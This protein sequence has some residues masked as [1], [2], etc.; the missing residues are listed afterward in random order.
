[1]DSSEATR[2]F[3]DMASLPISACRSAATH[4]RLPKPIDQG[5]RS[6]TVDIHADADGTSE[7]VMA[8]VG[9]GLQ[10]VQVDGHGA[11]KPLKPIERF[12]ERTRENRTRRAQQ[13]R[14][15]GQAALSSA[16]RPPILPSRRPSPP[17]PVPRPP[18]RLI[19]P[20]VCY[21][22]NLLVTRRAS[23]MLTRSR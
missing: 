5:S 17:Q 19:L 13:G 20:L 21:R 3:Q 23:G 8:A 11:S 14:M 15:C 18:T 2:C 1:M 16:A 12:L 7:T 9:A 4:G 6:C 10:V 22:A